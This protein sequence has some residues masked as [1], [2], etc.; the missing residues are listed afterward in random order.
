MKEGDRSPDAVVSVRGLSEL[1]GIREDDRLAIGAATRLCDVATDPAVRRIAPSLS[2]AASLIGSQQIRAIA[3]IGGNLCNAAP[4]ADTAAPLL[5]LDAQ[6]VLA[7]RRGERVVPAD[8]FFRGP[9]ETALQ[10][11]ELLKEIRVRRAEG[12]VG[13]SY[14]RHT[15][16]A[17]MDLAVASA[18]VW[19][20][21]DES[22]RIASSRI[23]LG[24]VAPTPLRADEAAALLVG[25][26]P[27]P[28]LLQGVAEAAALAAQPIDDVRA[29]AEYR[30]HLVRALVG[31]AVRLA[32][33]AARG[34][35]GD[36]R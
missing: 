2:D 27:T 34:T 18:A 7:S 15:P 10:P 36:T 6:F 23:A 25:H 12:R 13:A 26:A 24:A 14:I 16:R 11:D 20:T 5:S 8:A 32:I 9:G 21:V 4:S 1:R 35:E 3:T 19:L 22:D 33:A 28:E 30:R 31:R 17:R 29:S